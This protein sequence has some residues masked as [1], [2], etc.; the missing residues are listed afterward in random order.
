MIG[1]DE[2]GEHGTKLSDSVFLRVEDLQDTVR[3]LCEE[4]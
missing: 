1:E 4:D 3:T 2:S